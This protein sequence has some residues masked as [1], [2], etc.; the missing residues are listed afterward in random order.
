MGI[1]S[2]ITTV[3]IIVELG[4]GVGTAG[5]G[6]GTTSVGFGVG[7]VFITFIVKK[8]GLYLRNRI[9]W[10]FGHGLHAKSRLSGRYETI[11]WFTKSDRYTFNL[12][13]IRI[14]SKYPDKKHYRGPN[15]GKLSGNPMGKNPSDFWDLGEEWRGSVWDVPNVKSNHPE[16]SIHPCQFPVELAERCVLALTNENDWVLDPFGGVGSTA[17]A[18]LKNG[19]K[20]ISVEKEKKYVEITRNRISSLIKGDLKLRQMGKPVHVPVKKEGNENSSREV[21]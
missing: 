11:L 12:D 10:K 8:L 1:G 5:V 16:K 7:M 21:F 19:R 9:I 3:G 14:P 13:P 4:V 20:S 2:G 6:V 15:A 18:A 17:I